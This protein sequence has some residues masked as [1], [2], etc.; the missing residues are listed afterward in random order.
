MTKITYNDHP[1]LLFFSQDYKTRL[2]EL[3]FQTNGEEANYFLDTSKGLAQMFVIATAMNAHH[4]KDVS[5]NYIVT[6]EALEIYHND[7]KQ[8]Y[9]LFHD[10]VKTDIKSQFGTFLFPHGGQFAYIILGK[11]DTKAVKNI[12]DNYLCAANFQSNFFIGFDEGRII[13]GCLDDSP[14]TCFFTDGT[15]SGSYLFLIII[16]LALAQK[17]APLKLYQSDN[18]KETIYIL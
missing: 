14:K 18:I 17:N 10:F 11:N 15:P 16:L 9:H 2:D 7:K 12:S 3:T 6:P 4:N 5:T 13:N 8:R 1:F